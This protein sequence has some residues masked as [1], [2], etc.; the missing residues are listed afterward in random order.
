M[1]RPGASRTEGA[2]FAPIPLHWLD[3][4]PT[5]RCGVTWGVPFPRGVVRD[6][7]AHL[8]A[9]EGLPLPTQTW[10]LATWPDGSIKWLGL[11]AVVAPEHGH[12]L[13][14]WPGEGP[15]PTQAVTCARPGI[16]VFCRV[17][18]GA[19]TVDVGD[20]GVYLIQEIKRAGRS[21]TGGI[22]L[23]ARRQHVTAEDRWRVTRT[24]DCFGEIE[25][26]TIEQAGPVRAVVRV[27]G[28]HRGAETHRRWLPF[29]VRLEFYAGCDTVGVTHSMVY[30]GRADRDR[31][32][33]LGLTADVPLEAGPHNRQVRVVGDGGGL[34]CEPVRWLADVFRRFPSD[35]PQ[36]ALP[37]IQMAAR[38][39]DEATSDGLRPCFADFQLLQH[40]S[41]EFRLRKR[42]GPDSCWIDA[43]GGH[44]A[45]GLL[46]LGQDGGGLAILLREFWE[47]WPRALEVARADGPLA[48]ATAWLWSN[49]AEAMDLRHYGNRDY[50][51]TYEAVNPDP[52]TYSDAAGIARTSHL[53][54]WVMAPAT[55][56]DELPAAIEQARRPPL[57]V[58]DPAYYHGCRVVGAW[59][60]VDRGSPASCR[61]EDELLRHLEFYR[62][63]VEQRRWYGFWNYGD[64][65]L[66]YD[67][68]RK[69]W[70]YDIGGFAWWNAEFAG[71]LYWWYA[72]LRS[73][74]ADFFRLA[75]A[76][77]RHVAEVDTYHLGRWR[78]VGSRHNVVH[79]GCPCKEPR[80]S[81][82]LPKRVL[83]YLTA[84]PRMGDLLEEL[85]DADATPSTNDMLDGVRRVRIGPNW[86]AY[87]ANWM[88]A[89]ER[90]GDAKWRARIEH[91]LDGILS[92]P[93][94]LFQTD[95]FIYD[96]ATG[97]MTP[98]LDGPPF[99]SLLV[100]V[101][102]GDQMLIELES[103]LDRDD[104]RAAMV[105]LA[106]IACVPRSRIGELPAEIRRRLDVNPYTAKLAAWAAASGLAPELG[107][108]A[109][110]KFAHGEDRTAP[111]LAYTLPAQVTVHVDPLSGRT[112]QGWD[113]YLS[114]IAQWGQTAMALLA[115]APKDIPTDFL[116]S[117]D[118]AR[119]Q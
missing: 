65:M 11:T 107:R 24:E 48:T 39:V 88:T 29:R 111:D 96:A 36:E 60:P 70:R 93:L 40:G 27:D 5:R 19:I 97:S 21:V 95:P 18:T 35:A 44:R 119:P 15:V 54:L 67:Q 63:E 69:T 106:R 100:M 77:T 53:D 94:R 92:A 4:V 116:L 81:Q 102:G 30:D 41:D 42:T 34:W 3:T 31:I 82:A 26:L 22:R 68:D 17:D 90:T 45:P 98:C 87:A 113:Q 89:W 28:K 76:M 43:G 110:E 55:P 103:L 112:V 38:H 10:E 33:G 115:L 66:C 114:F 74:R 23:I 83:H 101:F 86:L 79:W 118:T 80:V 59:A 85:V 62:S 2:P 14:L 12:A 9:E 57:P 51:P 75:A 56:N 52:D 16:E 78:G 91:G 46:A 1:T 64:G 117:P 13:T 6:P 72:F 25:S 50:R 20:R 8:R 32:A 7:I 37:A 73:G 49:E 71:D 47:A 104:L 58:A 108:A 99:S 109:W 84:D 105:D 61:V